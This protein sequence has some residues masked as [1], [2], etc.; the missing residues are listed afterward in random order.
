MSLLGCILTHR[1]RA[2]RCGGWP[3]AEM[4][5]SWF[6]SL[7]APSN[8][9][10][11]LPGVKKAARQQRKRSGKA[12]Q[13][14]ARHA[15]NA[16][17]SSKVC[18][19]DALVLL[20]YRILSSVPVPGEGLRCVDGLPWLTATGTLCLM[21]TCW[22]RTP[23]GLPFGVH[24]ARRACKA[25]LQWTTERVMHGIS[26]A[27]QESRQV[28]AGRPLQGGPSGQWQRS[29]PTVCLSLGEKHLSVTSHRPGELKAAQQAAD[30]SKHGSPSSRQLA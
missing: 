11:L 7:P 12:A 10:C 5:V 17:Q 6:L 1:C 25:R 23:E 28:V 22:G 8:T 14:R 18:H 26:A 21:F 2:T 9:C 20:R 13:G 27:W 16:E 30:V 3:A 15:S 4:C 29:Q 19:Q 24:P